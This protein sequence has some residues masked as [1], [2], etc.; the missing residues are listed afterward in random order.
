V[1]EVEKVHGTYNSTFGHD[2][3]HRVDAASKDRKRGSG[4]SEKESAPEEDVVELHEDGAG[5]VTLEPTKFVES[6]G[7]DFSA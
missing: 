3:R 1:G 5:S 6:D 2:F 4:G 7:I